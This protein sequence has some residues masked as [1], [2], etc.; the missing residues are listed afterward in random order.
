METGFSRS[1]RRRQIKQKR[2]LI[3]AIFLVASGPVCS[4]YAQIAPPVCLAKSDSTGG[5]MR[6]VA[7]DA[8]VAKFETAG[9][10]RFACPTLTREI[11]QG[12]RDR[13]SRLRAHN[14][15]ARSVIEGLYG[16]A[17]A[18]MCRATDAWVAAQAVR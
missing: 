5:R 15:Y 17:V 2:I 9:F 4:A 6:F 16:L 18:D 7:I 13:C 8:D 14:A 1:R 10:R 12:Q 11:V 3:V